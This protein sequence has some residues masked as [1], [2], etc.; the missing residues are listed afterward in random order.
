MNE[1]LYNKSINC[2]VCKHKIE[3][4]RVRSKACRVSCRDTDFCIHYENINPLLYDVWVC[5]FCGYA[6]LSDRFEEIDSKTAEA[7]L[8]NIA[9]RW[10]K[11]DFSGERTLDVAIEAFKLALLN[12]QLRKA[13]SS[14]IAKLCIRIAWL[15]R[16]KGEEKEKEFLQYAVNCYRDVFERER[17]PVDKLDENTC[18]YVIGELYRRIGNLDESVK[19]FSRLISSPEARKNAK[20]M[21]SAREQFQLAK[22]EKEK[23][24]V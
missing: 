13:K 4:T 12:L 1:A 20:L 5:E 16:F 7:V 11:R 17:F 2:P 24:G 8:K 18:L 19:W 6:A 22:E 10:K 9:P 23:S 3:V 15:Y 21:D 14:E